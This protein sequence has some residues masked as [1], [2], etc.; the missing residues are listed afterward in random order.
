MP[1]GS[2]LVVVGNLTGEKLLINSADILFND[3]LVRGFYLFVWF[4]KTSKEE[5]FKNIKAVADDL[6]DGG[7]IFGTEISKQ[8]S[9]SEF[10]EAIAES[11]KVATEGK[12]LI[13]CD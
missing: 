4:S 13:K 9:L 8:M 10:K 5:L 7:A 1:Y 12:I 3:K 2:E 11:T 6:R